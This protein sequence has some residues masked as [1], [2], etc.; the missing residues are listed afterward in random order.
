M[1][2]SNINRQAI[3]EFLNKDKRFDGRGLKDY[4]DIKI[5]IGVSKNAEGSARVKFG[6]CEVVAGVKID[7]S[8]PYPDGQD[9]GTLMTTMEFLPMASPDFEAGP[10]G[11]A[12]IETARIID[13]GIRESGFIDFKKLCIKEGEKV[14]SIMLDLFPI[15]ADGNL[16]DLGALAAVVALKTAR[17]PKYNEKTERI[18][19]GEWTNK[20]LPLTDKTPIT[21]TAHK[22]G[23]KILFDPVNEEEE[24]S[25]A[26]VSLCFTYN[27]KEIMI[28]AAQ[29]GGEKSFTE[30]EFEEVIDSAAE[31][32]KEL[33]VKI[34][35]E[36]KKIGKND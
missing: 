1:E 5:E 9:E 3:E 28:N 7:V 26:R 6:D 22:M 10:P 2:I 11:I 32:Y 17:M 30:K 23:S 27:G 31:K 19:H 36:I 14:Y 20:P 15:N 12:S 35:K 4:R 25:E 13:R 29:K 24:S 21:I 16:I 8:T 33:E 18:E 34:E